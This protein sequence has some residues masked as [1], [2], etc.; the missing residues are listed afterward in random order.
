MVAAAAVEW[1][2][3][4]ITYALL[5]LSEVEGRLAVREPRPK[6]RLDMI[7]DLLDIN[8]IEV[9]AD[10]ATIR[11]ALETADTQRNQLAH[12]IWVRDSS[13]K[14]LFLRITNGQ[15]QPIKNQKGKTKRLVDPQGIQFTVDDAKSLSA[16][17][18]ATITALTA[19]NVEVVQALSFRNK[20]K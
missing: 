13:S 16:L 6:E 10:I 19:L 14:E 5:R 8:K 11:E 7:K 18:D 17:F 4:R 1:L 12:G 20:S 15:W 2:L 3:A 9:A